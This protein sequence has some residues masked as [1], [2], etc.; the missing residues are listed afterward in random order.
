[1][2]FHCERVCGV[3]VLLLFLEL[4]NSH[5]QVTSASTISRDTSVAPE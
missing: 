5:W 2:G 3:W 4:D 1:M